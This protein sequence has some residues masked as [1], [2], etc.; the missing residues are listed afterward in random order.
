MCLRCVFLFRFHFNLLRQTESGIA[1]GRIDCAMEMET[2]GS[3]NRIMKTATV[4]LNVSNIDMRLPLTM[5]DDADSL[6][7]NVVT[8]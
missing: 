7:Q 4:Q 6:S 3:V 1:L 2:I 8:S 5:A